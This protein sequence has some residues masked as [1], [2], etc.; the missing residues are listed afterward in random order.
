M[1]PYLGHIAMIIANI[2]WGLNAPFAKIAQSTEHIS[3]L[4]L[5]T[6]QVCGSTLL[7]WL[8][9]FFSP[10]EKI[11]FADGFKFFIASILGITLNQACFIF[12]VHRTSPIN[13][14]VVCTA[15]PI[16]TLIVSSLYLKEKIAGKKAIG[17]LIGAVGALLL[18]FGNFSANQSAGN[19]WGDLIVL[20]GQVGFASYLVLFSGIRKYSLVTL[21][22]WMFLFS[23][24][25][26]IPFSIGD[27]IQIQVAA[28]PI[29]VVLSTLY[30]VVC[31]TFFAYICISIGQKTLQPTVISMYN[32]LQPV[33]ATVAAIILGM[34]NF[35]GIK[36]MAILLVFIGVYFVN[37]TNKINS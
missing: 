21:M 10:K 16:V 26:F 30:V 9:S 1:K 8:M 29:P 7:F 28:I 32:Y 24:I 23:S 25:S 11:S 31:A 14:S 13:A 19:I 27:I 15:L 22:K 2:I 3:S 20:L 35:G 6:L 12:G 17:I 37:K 34:D 36:A 5:V 33:V 18:I 4:T